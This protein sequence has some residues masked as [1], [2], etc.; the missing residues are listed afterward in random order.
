LTDD[1]SLHIG[2]NQPYDVSDTNDDTIPLFG[3]KMG[4]PHLLVE[5]RQDLIDRDD[6][7]AR[8]AERLIRAFQHLNAFIDKG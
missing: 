7:R 8:W 5:I 3:E 2:L 4:F 1:N 6:I